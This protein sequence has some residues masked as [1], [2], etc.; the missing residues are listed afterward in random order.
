MKFLTLPLILFLISSHSFASVNEP[1]I[2]DFL[3]REVIKKMSH[4][5]K[6]FIIYKFTSSDYCT[7]ALGDEDSALKMKKECKHEAKKI[8]TFLK[9]HQNEWHK[10][11]NFYDSSVTKEGTDYSF[12]K[13]LNFT[14]TAPMSCFISFNINVKKSENMTTFFDLYCDH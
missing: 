6:S 3:N 5:Y 10:D 12:I 2:S 9:R 8:L 7:N 4:E 1:K 14:P 11:F 13:I